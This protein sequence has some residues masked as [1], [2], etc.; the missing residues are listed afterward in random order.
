[1]TL[2]KSTYYRSFMRKIPAK[3]SIVPV[4][5]VTHLRRETFN[6]KG[7]EGTRKTVKIDTSSILPSEDL[8]RECVLCLRLSFDQRSHGGWKRIWNPIIKTSP[9][10]LSTP[11]SGH[12]DYNQKIHQKFGVV[13]GVISCPSAYSKH[14]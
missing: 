8:R 10:A 2:T 14:V 3:D 6:L 1:M 13:Y 9:G 5:G 11:C 4:V 7:Y 12:G